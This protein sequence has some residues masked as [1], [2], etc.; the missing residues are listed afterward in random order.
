VSGAFFDREQALRRLAGRQHWVVTHRQLASLGFSRHA[1]DHRLQGG[2]LFRVYRGVYAV[3]RRVLSATGR[4]LAAVLAHGPG[5]V[6]SHVSAA[7]QWQ[8]LQTSQTMIDVSVPRRLAV[9]RGI[10]LHFTSTLR[11]EDLTTLDTIPITSVERTLADLASQL[12]PEQLLEAV[13][14]AYVLRQ[15]DL[16]AMRRVLERNANHSGVGALHVIFDDFTQAPATR[17]V[18]ERQMLHVLAAADLPTPLLNVTVAGLEV[19]MFWP[20]WRLVVELDSRRFHDN[21]WAMERDRRRDTILR[22]AR[23]EIL[24]VT[25]RR[26]TRTPDQ[27]VADIHALAA[28]GMSTWIA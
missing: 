24:R 10:R 19:D 27:V 5:A 1:I 17:S 28:I 2:Q 14:Q 18:L 9:R 21:P 3:G 23:C 16:A 26:L 6:L 20:D 15:L 13:E 12:R 25:H 4:R 11:A 7:A 8:L 22:K